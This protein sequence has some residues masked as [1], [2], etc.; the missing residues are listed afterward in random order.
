METFRYY[1]TQRP[2]APG[3]FPRPTGCGVV[4]IHNFDRRTPIHGLPRPA[5]GYIEYSHP[6]PET[7]MRNYELTAAPENA[8]KGG[9][10]EDG[11]V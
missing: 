6:L 9:L 2:V 8:G 3:V 1:S 11:E 4:H 10:F 7:D 5:W